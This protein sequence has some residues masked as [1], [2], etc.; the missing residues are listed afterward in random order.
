MESKTFQF[1]G[2]EI[3]FEMV[4]ENVVVMPPKWQKCLTRKYQDF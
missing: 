1:N 4:G 3:A 2:K